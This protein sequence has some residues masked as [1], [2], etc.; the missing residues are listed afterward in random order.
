MLVEIDPALQKFSLT[1]LAAVSNLIADI[2]GLET[3]VIER[4]ML[5]KNTDFAKRIARDIIEV[6]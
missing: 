2:T 3:T 5:A 1:D 6:F 4:K